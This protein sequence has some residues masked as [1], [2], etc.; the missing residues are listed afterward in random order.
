[1]PLK[2]TLIEKEEEVIY[3]EKIEKRPLTI[4]KNRTTNRIKVSFR[5]K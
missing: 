2:E 4:S 5:T 1:M 3:E